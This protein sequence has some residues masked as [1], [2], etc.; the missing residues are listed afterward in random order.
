M[1]TRIS[2]RK[3]NPFE[4]RA[5]FLKSHR[6]QT[7]HFIYPGKSKELLYTRAREEKGELHTLFPPSS[8]FFQK[9]RSP[10]FRVT[11]SPRLDNSWRVRAGR[12]RAIHRAIHP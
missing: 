5:T 1:E 3:K 6:S 11:F 10:P 4:W 12:S 8:S 9:I 7:P 2:N